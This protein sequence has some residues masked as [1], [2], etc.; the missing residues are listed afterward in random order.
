MKCYRLLRGYRSKPPLAIH[1]FAEMATQFSA[2][3]HD[4]GD[5]MEAADINPVIVNTEAAVAVDALILPK[6]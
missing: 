5:V 2:L 4:L 1:A 6:A 3:V